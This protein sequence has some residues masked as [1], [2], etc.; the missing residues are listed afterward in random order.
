MSADNW[1]LPTWTRIRVTVVAPKTKCAVEPR[2]NLTISAPDSVSTL[3]GRSSGEGNLIAADAAI[4][5]NR[6]SAGQIRISTIQGYRSLGIFERSRA[7]VLCNAVLKH[8]MT[9]TSAKPHLRYTALLTS[10]SAR[11]SEANSVHPRESPTV[12]QLLSMFC[13]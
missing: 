6:T 5:F 3:T 11:I 9:P 10:L 12:L 7:A 13:L 8:V 1:R 4:V 2:S